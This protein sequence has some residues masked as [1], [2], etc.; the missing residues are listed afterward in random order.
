MQTTSSCILFL[1]LCIA[2]GS[3]VAS[4]ENHFPHAVEPASGVHFPLEMAGEE[5]TLSLAGSTVRV[6]KV[7]F[8]N[9]QV[10]YRPL[11]F[12]SS[13]GDVVVDN[14]L[15]VTP[16]SATFSAIIGDRCMLLGST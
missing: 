2:T 8:V 4:V 16:T 10:R 11:S 15:S 1:V 3:L 5:S 6:K 9:V 12:W 13:I 14:L 7:V